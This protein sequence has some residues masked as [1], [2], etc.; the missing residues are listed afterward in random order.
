[1]LNNFRYSKGSK[2]RKWDLHFHTPSSYDYKNKS[3][4]NNEII[5]E[6]LKNEM[7]A[8]AITDHHY[9]DLEKIKDLQKLGQGQITV[10]PG[11]EVRTDQTGKENIHLIGIF[12]EDSN[13]DLIWTDMQS[14]GMHPDLVKEKTDEKVYVKFED[15][16]NKVHKNNG[17]VTIHAGSKSSSVENIT[18]SLSHKVAL[19]LDLLKLY[20]VFD[21]GKVSDIKEYEEHVLP[22][23]PKHPPMIICSDNHNIHNYEVKS[24]CWIKADPTFEGL[25]QILFEPAT[26]V[27]IQEDAPGEKINYLVIDKVRFLDKSDTPIF[28]KEW[29]E[30]NPNLNAII[31]GK[32]SGKSLLL[33]HIAK[34]ID[35]EQVKDRVKDLSMPPYNKLEENEKF[36]FEVL[37][38][39]GYTQKLKGGSKGENRRITYIPQMYINK[40][41][42][43]EAGQSLNRLILDVLMQDPKFK[44]F[45]EE[46]LDLIRERKAAV[47]TLVITLFGLIDDLKNQKDDLKKLGDKNAIDREISRITLQIEGLRTKSGFSEEDNKKYK[48]LD[49]KRVLLKRERDK[50]LTIKECIETLEAFVKNI[51]DNIAYDLDVEVDSHINKFDEDDEDAIKILESVRENIKRSLEK[52]IPQIV[53]ENFAILGNYS[54]KL[55]DLETKTE[56]TTNQLSPFLEKI[57]NQTLL[58]KLQVDVDSQISV[59][60]KIEAREKSIK[61]T[62]RKIGQTKE[63]AFVNYG[64]TYQYYQDIKTE[65]LRDKYRKIGEDLELQVD[66]SFDSKR[67][68]NEFESMLDKRLDIRLDF[69]FF[70]VKNKQYRFNETNHLDRIKIMF[71]LLAKGGSE[72]VKLKSEV[73]PKDS[74][75]KLLENYFLI[76]FGLIQNGDAIIDMSPGKGG[77]VLLKLFLHLSNAKDPILIDQPED[78]LDNRTIYKELNDFTM[79]SKT[80]RQIIM[81]SHNPNLVVSTDSEEIIVANQSGQ[82]DGRDNKAYRFEYVSGALENRFHNP[83]EQGILFQKGIRDHV[84]EILEGGQEAFKKRE[85]KY[86]F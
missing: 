66:L 24:W 29:I 68:T 35:Q 1:M 21:M 31:G 27:Q 57:E 38:K 60:R 6:L 56:S 22:N 2:W 40:L 28:S 77:I 16:C 49:N 54:K 23:I 50:I 85:R 39:D 12:P 58:K 51:P 8:V 62:E 36:N 72:N 42:E 69:P 61:A 14:L 84:C 82:Q 4:S 75:L 64:E 74:V 80:N 13:I 10:F 5:D 7:S 17:I 73:T 43:K 26:R 9:M 53:T 47:S 19:K 18:N 76:K 44:D 41:A 46:K 83:D 59:L 55:A 79:E 34:T 67:F 30:L 20:D 45:Y 37:W 3:V 11:I 48:E 63:T 71:D 33:Y 78:N 52:H 86:D 15:F 32:S 81:V 70:G 25:K 65:L